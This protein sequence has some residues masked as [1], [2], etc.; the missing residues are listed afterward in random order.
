[1]DSKNIMKNLNTKNNL[2]KIN[3]FIVENISFRTKINGKVVVFVINGRIISQHPLAEMFVEKYRKKVIESLLRILSYSI[4]ED[5]NKEYQNYQS[6]KIFLSQENIPIF[7]LDQRTKL[8]TNMGFSIKSQLG[9][10]STLLNASK[11]TNFTYL[12]EG[13]DF[14]DDEIQEINAISTRTK[15]IDRVEAIWRKG[16]K[17]KFEKVDNNTFAR[18]LNMIDTGLSVLL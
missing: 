14:T 6:E 15:I 13:Y 10:D 1:M 16:A 8:N 3:K 11:A 9:G 7:I 4:L 18:N 5:T 17:L 2:E 12:V